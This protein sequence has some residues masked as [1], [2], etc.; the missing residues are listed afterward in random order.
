MIYKPSEFAGFTIIDGF[1]CH[2]NESGNHLLVIPDVNHKGV[3]IKGSIIDNTHKI[4]IMG[5]YGHSKT[6]SYMRKF[7][8]WVTLAKDVEK[9]CASCETCRTTKR[10][11]MKPHGLLHNLPIP[12]HPWSGIAMDFVGPFP[13]SLGKNYLWVIICC[14]TITSTLNTHKHNDENS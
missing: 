9:F 2:L 14:L 7:Y 5:H 3:G 12:D 8:W 6:L 1:L 13:E 4:I 10:C 11:T